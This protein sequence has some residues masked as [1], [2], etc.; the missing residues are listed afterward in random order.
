M[1]DRSMKRR[2]WETEGVGGEKEEEWITEDKM[3]G[4][5]L[6]GKYETEEEVED[7]DGA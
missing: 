2:R 1:E 7:K 4:N 5:G 6:Q 3:R